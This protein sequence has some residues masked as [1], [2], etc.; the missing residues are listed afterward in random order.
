MDSASPTFTPLAFSLCSGCYTCSGRPYVRSAEILPDPLTKLCCLVQGCVHLENEEHLPNLPRNSLWVSNGPP[1]SPGPSLNWEFIE[2]RSCSTLCCIL[3]EDSHS[4]PASWSMILS[5]WPGPYPIASEG[6][7]CFSSP[8]PWCICRS[9][10][11][12]L[13]L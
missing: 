12:P 7:C 2:K 11:Q 10:R 5:E 1:Y 3:T 4:R 6:V 9:G 13:C 8:P